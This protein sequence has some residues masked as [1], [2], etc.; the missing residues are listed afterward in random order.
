M[1]LVRDS[2]GRDHW[3]HADVRWNR[4]CANR[5]QGVCVLHRTGHDLI[6]C[7]LRHPRRLLTLMRWRSLAAMRGL[8]HDAIGTLQGRLML[9]VLAVTFPSLVRLVTVGGPLAGT[10][11]DSPSRLGA[12][13]VAQIALTACFTV[14][15]PVMLL[16]SLVM[17]R[18]E[19]PLVAHPSV[20]P[21]LAALQVVG[22]ILGT[23]SFLWTFFYLFYGRI[24]AAEVGRSSYGLGIHL[25]A[26]QLQFVVLGV[27]LAAAI[28]GLLVG[29]RLV[30]RAKRLQRLSV[31]PF[32]V[33][34]PLFVLL[35][36]FLSRHFPGWLS[37]PGRL[38]P[39]F[40]F[41][42]QSPLAIPVV[43]RTGALWT[44]ALWGGVLLAAVCASGLALW[45]WRWRAL[46]E[47]ASATDG[48][49]VCNPPRALPF[50][51][52]GPAL[53]RHAQLFWAKDL[54][55]R[56]ADRR[57]TNFRFHAMVLLIA[58]IGVFLIAE[59]PLAGLPASVPVQVG[60]SQVLIGTM[61]FLG[62]ARTLGCL[63][64]EGQQL[65]LLRPVLSMK[66]LFLLKSLVNAGYLLVHAPFYAFTIGLAARLTGLEG[67]SLG[68]LVIDAAI[69]GLIFSTLGSA[70]GFLLPDFSRRSLLFPGATRIAQ[71]LFLA[72]AGLATTGH[73]IWS[74]F[75]G[76][77][78]IDGRRFAG[79][80]GAM[81]GSLLVLTSVVSIWG[82]R[83]TQG[84]EI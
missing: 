68:T 46:E 11:L 24:L 16:K 36:S 48:E 52:V 84:M 47:L 19:E 23:S 31:A 50:P 74:Y 40:L 35:P 17:R 60:A 73:A 56:N 27:L 26:A 37:G 79:M 30:E 9:V 83:R 82:I 32:L 38:A 49:S 77:G 8:A 4:V 28:R 7:G 78:L 55:G 3:S 14:M 63:G 64:E 76:V 20:L 58:I 2:A 12:L 5:Q 1:D 61:A 51:E 43:L 39:E 59:F 10:A 57:R 54:L 22:A 72:L 33:S 45:G 70:W 66:R 15:V 34:F 75:E 62:M 41:F 69:A 13:L 65:L 53:V 29:S 25:G 80:I 67:T 6:R 18:S 44:A 71:L 81:M 42:F 21:D